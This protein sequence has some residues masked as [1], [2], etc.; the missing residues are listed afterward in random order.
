MTKAN[1]DGQSNRKKNVIDIEDLLDTLLPMQYDKLAG[2]IAYEM[3]LSPDTV[4]YSFLSM[5]MAKKIIWMDR[6]RIVYL[7]EKDPEPEQKPEL[8]EGL[9]PNPHVEPDAESLAEYAKKHPRKPEQPENQVPKES[10]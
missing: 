3:N 8:P 4:K 2:I 9:K 6:H 10:P 5:F 7:S 1:T